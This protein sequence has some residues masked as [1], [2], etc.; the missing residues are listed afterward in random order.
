MSHHSCYVAPLDGGD[1]GQ[2]TYRGRVS[3]SYRFAGS[4]R[5][6]AGHVLVLAVMVT[7][8]LLGRWQLDVSDA[9]GFSLQN[10]GYALQWWAFSLFGGGL[11][12]KIVRDNAGRPGAASTSTSLGDAA[13]SADGAA[14]AQRAPEPIIYRRYVMPDSTQQPDTRDD[15]LLSEYNDY[16]AALAA[17]DAAEAPEQP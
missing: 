10:F 16:L 17:H 11:W 4:P 15:P 6:V 3:R 7:M 14:G 1:G 5:W 13:P 12:L 2:L 8:V 9:K